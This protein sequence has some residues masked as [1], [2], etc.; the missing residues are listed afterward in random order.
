MEGAYQVGSDKTNAMPT[1]TE[2][3]QIGRCAAA[4][5][6]NYVDVTKKRADLGSFPKARPLSCAA[7]RSPAPLGPARADT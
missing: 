4:C 2:A 7:A 6:F 1:S 5:K 3:E